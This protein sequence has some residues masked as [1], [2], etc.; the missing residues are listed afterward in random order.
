MQQHF[1]KK[2]IFVCGTD[3]GVGKTIVAAAL[4]A[5]LNAQGIRTGAYKPAE[6]GCSAKNS[7]HVQRADSEFLK[8]SAKMSEALDLIN[9]YYFREALAPGL[10]AEREGK[11]ISFAKIRKNLRVLQKNY[12]VIFVE[13]A[14][15]LL[16]PVSGKRTNLDLIKFLKIPVIVV[17]RL[18]LG[19]INH[20]RL[21]LTHLKAH[22]V[23][24]LGVILSDTVGGKSV[25]EKT[26]PHI[27]RKMGVAVLGVLPHLKSPNPKNL[28][29]AASQ[30]GLFSSWE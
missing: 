28:A 14:G 30:T 26:N 9:P 2:A 17:G 4:C 25:A 18:G 15:G 5:G 13:G 22:R 19:T 1:R 11:K 20:T 7:G 8:K 21:T 6:S 12:D 10:A 29:K 3:T 23:P 27:L 16:V 24:V